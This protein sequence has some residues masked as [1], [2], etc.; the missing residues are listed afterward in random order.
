MEMSLTR[1]ALVIVL[2]AAAAAGGCGGQSKE[3]KAQA[4]VCDARADISKQVDK[5]KGLTLATATVDGIRDSVSAIQADLKKIADAQGTLGDARRT[6]VQTATK[7]FTASVT[8][9]VQ[10]LGG[11]LSLSEAGSQLQ[12]AA[13]QLGTAYAQ[14]LGKLDGC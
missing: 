7:Q 8:A 10:G 6:E 12:T 2:V 1:R 14:S 4:N 3:E 13:K 11:N 5:L 9:I